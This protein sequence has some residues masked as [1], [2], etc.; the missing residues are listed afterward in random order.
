MHLIIE[1]YKSTMDEGRD[2]TKVSKLVNSLSEVF[3]T[4]IT[5]NQKIWA[6][7]AKSLL[8]AMILYLLDIGYQNDCIDKLNMYSVY[9]F[10]LEN[11]TKIITRTEKVEGQTYITKSTALDLIFDGLPLGHPAKLAYTTSRM[12][13]GE[14]KSSINAVLSNNLSIFGSDVG[15]SKLTAQNDINIDDLISHEKPCAIFMV[16]P[17]EDKSRNVLSSLFITQCYS[18]LI[19]LAEAFPQQKLPRRVQFVL[20]EFG[21][22]TTIPDMDTKITISLGR[23][24]LFNL[25]VQDLNQLDSKYKGTAKTIRSNCGNVIYINSL[26]PDT[27]ECISR[28]LGSETAEYRTYSGNLNEFLKNQTVNVKSKRLLTSDELARLKFGE[29]IIQRQRCYPIHSKFKPFYKL[30]LPVTALSDICK[31]LKLNSNISLEDKLFPLEYAQLPE[32]EPEYLF[33]EEPVKHYQEQVAVNEEKPDIKAAA[34]QKLDQQT[35]N[36]FGAALTL[37]DTPKCTKMLNSAR[38]MNCINADEFAAVQELIKSIAEM[39]TNKE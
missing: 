28:M 20:D 25:F 31:D 29:V 38:M 32:P 4:D 15:I 35:K 34:L 23:N 21:N 17:D 1:E 24:I 27:N 37:G 16:L 10:F 2:L 8:S 9:N 19:T 11:T 26:D 3:T 18:R 22:L 33:T 14:M 6:E 36:K 30:G 7:S 39:N 12:A 5:A 13:S